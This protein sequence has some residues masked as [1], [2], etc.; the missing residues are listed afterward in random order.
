MKGIM[1]FIVIFVLFQNP[2]TAETE[3]WSLGL[4]A[5]GQGLGFGSYVEV[6]LGGSSR[7]MIGK[8]ESLDAAGA[9]VFISHAD[10]RRST[11]LNYVHVSPEHGTRLEWSLGVARIKRSYDRYF[12]DSRDFHASADAVTAAFGVRADSASNSWIWRVGVSPVLLLDQPEP[13]VH[14]SDMFWRAYVTLGFGF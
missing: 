2:V 12:S 11:Y 8:G 7:I 4:T 10:R 5:G 1:F 6:P 14:D 13:V 9:F 3:T